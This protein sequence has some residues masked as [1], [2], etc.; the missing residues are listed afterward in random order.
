MSLSEPLGQSDAV[1][2]PIEATFPSGAPG[3]G[4]G[5]RSNEA[6][7]STR[8]RRSATLT[9]LLDGPGWPWLRALTDL[10]GLLTAVT[11]AAGGNDR[12]LRLVPVVP[13][14]LALF[15]VGAMYRRRISASLLRTIMTVISSLATSIIALAIWSRY[16]VGHPLP[17]SL[18]LRTFT[19]CFAAVLAE[20][21]TLLGA[22]Q[23]T[24]M[25]GVT[26]T[27]TLIVGAGKIGIQLAQRIASRRGYGL[28]P[29]GFIDYPETADAMLEVKTDLPLLGQPEELKDIVRR[30]RAGHVVISF[31]RGRDHELV[32]LIRLCNE[33]RLDVSLV[34]RLF[35]SINHRLASDSLGPLPL[36]VMQPTNPRSWEFACKHVIDGTVAAL[37]LV[38][39][40][41]LLAALAL[42]V[43]LSSPGPVLFS[44]WRVGRDGQVFKMLKFRTMHVGEPVAWQGPAAG[45]AP[46]GVE[47]EDRRTTIGRV[48][49]RTSLDEL[50]Q[51]W[52]VMRGEMSLVGPRP[53]RPEFVEMFRGEVRRY[54]DRHRVKSGITG[55]AQVNGLRG[56][57][58]L[59]DRIDWD[60]YY[61]ENW[62]L[63]LDAKILAHTVLAV[64]RP[65]E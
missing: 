65:A 60:N 36:H 26:A 37:G 43:K 62:S 33:M 31:A 53:E 54:D 1:A 45:L 8:G 49:R 64:F 22:R 55:A 17:Q 24:R 29:I 12:G 16:V 28:D 3:L 48:I 63:A 32:P 20:R 56:K 34:P 47:G 5:P 19:F 39:L 25:L 27:P 13:S 46:G 9:W 18:L 14:A 59:A 11:L 7:G 2:F 15:W 4:M 35:E 10:T 30:T 40:S 57:T 52:N 23:L 42:L 58:G 44:Q 6:V 21:T 38:L 50:P 61:I 41:P 51:L